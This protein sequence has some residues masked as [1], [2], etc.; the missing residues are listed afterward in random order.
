[1]SSTT[2]CQRR[3]FGPRDVHVPPP[4]V[5]VHVRRVGAGDDLHER[6]HRSRLYYD[7]ALNRME[8]AEESVMDQLEKD[9][10]NLGHCEHWTCSASGYEWTGSSS[11]CW[12]CRER[13]EDDDDDGTD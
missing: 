9:N 2:A 10:E 12:N 7:A 11:E 5:G 8:G 1:M 3:V 6:H 4:L 13:Q